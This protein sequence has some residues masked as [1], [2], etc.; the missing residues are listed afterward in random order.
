MMSVTP[1]SAA[2]SVC[3]IR[4]MPAI[5]SRVMLRSEPPA[6]PS[7]MMQYATS[8]PSPVQVATEPEQP[9]SMSSGWAATMPRVA[10][11]PALHVNYAERVLPIRDGLPELKDFPAEMGGS[12][13][14]LPE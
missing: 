7:V 3:S 13:V 1:T 10:F 6:S 11:A 5:C 8:T 12:G 9:K 4:L 2:A 14:V